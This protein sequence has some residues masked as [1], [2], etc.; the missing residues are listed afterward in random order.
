MEGTPNKSVEDAKLRRRRPVDGPGG[1]MF[2]TECLGEKLMP[3]F[4]GVADVA[5]S[6]HDAIPCAWKTR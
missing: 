3:E 2:A 1:C 5:Y 6:Q 4:Q